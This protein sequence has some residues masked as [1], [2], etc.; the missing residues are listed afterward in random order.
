MTSVLED[1][2]EHGFRKD[3]GIVRT[4]VQQQ[5]GPWIWEMFLGHLL[6]RDEIIQFLLIELIVHKRRGEH[7]L[8]VSITILR[9]AHDQ[10][11]G[12]DGSLFVQQGRN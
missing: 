2:L 1:A 12:E 8:V 6:S 4:I 9:P 7:L 5:H 3:F 11:H 10:T